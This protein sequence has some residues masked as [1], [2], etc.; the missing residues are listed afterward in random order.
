[1]AD[2]GGFRAVKGQSVG[3]TEGEEG[4]AKVSLLTFAHIYSI[5]SSIDLCA[6]AT[7]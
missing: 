5:T 2:N 7:L 3:E 6:R 4:G 1:M